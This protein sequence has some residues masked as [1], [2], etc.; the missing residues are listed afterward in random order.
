[1]E[2]LRGAEGRY[3]ELLAILTD[4]QW[5]T[6]RWPVYTFLAGVMVGHAATQ[7]VCNLQKFVPFCHRGNFFVEDWSRTSCDL[8]NSLKRY[9]VYH[10]HVCSV[11]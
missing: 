8:D 3:A 1:M 11:V 7:G 2:G 5:P 6:P 9:V 10:R 4:S